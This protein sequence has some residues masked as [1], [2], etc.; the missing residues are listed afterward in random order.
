MNCTKNWSS[1]VEIH[2]EDDTIHYTEVSE[3]DDSYVIV[4]VRV[5]LILAVFRGFVP[6]DSVLAIELLL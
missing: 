4:E 2:N 5:C 1:F 6:V 3:Y